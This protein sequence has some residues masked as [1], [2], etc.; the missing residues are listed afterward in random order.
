MAMTRSF[1]SLP[2][3]VYRC[4]NWN[5]GGGHTQRAPRLAGSRANQS[6]RGCPG[7]DS[8]PRQRDLI[9]S[10]FILANQVMYVDLNI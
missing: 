3:R 4:D 10:R 2:I 8:W 5:N 7:P 9:L 6:Y 1:Q